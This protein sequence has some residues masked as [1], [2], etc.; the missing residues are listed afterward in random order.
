MLYEVITGDKVVTGG[1]LVGTIEKMSD[2]SDEVIVDL[3]GGIPTRRWPEML[4]RSGSWPRL[5][6]WRFPLRFLRRYVFFD[7]RPDFVAS[8]NFV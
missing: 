5:L 4:T 1:G 3:G 8:Y 7:W 6:V 2:G